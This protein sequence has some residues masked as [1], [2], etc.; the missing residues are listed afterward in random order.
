MNL[1]AAAK[2]MAE[3]PGAMQLRTLQTISTDSAPPP[4]TRSFWRYMAKPRHIRQQVGGNG[5]AREIPDHGAKLWLDVECQAVIDGPRASRQI[6]NAV[7]GLS[8]RV[9]EHPVQQCDLLGRGAIALRGRNEVRLRVMLDEKLHRADSVWAV[10]RNSRR[11]ERPADAFAYEIRGDLSAVERSV[12]EVPERRFTSARLVDRMASSRARIFERDEERAVAP[13]HD[14]P[15]LHD[16]GCAEALY[17]AHHIRRPARSCRLAVLVITVFRLACASMGHRLYSLSLGKNVPEARERCDPAK[18]QPCAG[19]TG[20][21]VY[22]RATWISVS[23]ARIV[24]AVW[25]AGEAPQVKAVLQRVTRASVR[26]V[27]GAANTGPHPERGIGPGFLVLLGVAREDVQSDADRIVDRIA[28]LRVFPD[29]LGKMNLS[30]KQIQGELLVVSQFTL[31]ADTRR[32][33]R[34]SFAAAAGPEQGN[35]LY[36]YT[37]DRLRIAG[38]PVVTGEFGAHMHVELVNDGPVT[39]VLDTREPESMDKP[40]R[41]P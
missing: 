28:G 4:P 32:G 33:R 24:Q 30:I 7:L 22:C 20:H 6:L 35:A 9:I 12:R 15:G 17:E 16:P 3:S 5:L 41:D 10:A 11:H 8:I 21:L 26:V 31:L 23:T 13:P 18:R 36:T 34:P 27:S 1:A 2:T 39:I 19:A 14:R 40:L 37:V 38:L 25:Y 29:E